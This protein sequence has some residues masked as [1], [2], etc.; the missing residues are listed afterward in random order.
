MMIAEVSFGI[1]LSIVIFL[2][3]IV[4]G[5][6][7][8]AIMIDERLRYLRLIIF[9]APSP[10]R[11]DIPRDPEPVARYL[12]WALGENR[13]PVAC[14]HL[15]HTGRIRYGKTGR[16]MNMGGEGYFSL[17]VPGFIWHATIT[18]APGIWLDAFD[19]Y[20]DREAGM[21]LNLFSLIPL[22]NNNTDEIKNSSLFHYLVWTPVFPMIHGLSDFITWEN[23]DDSTAKAIIQ[24]KDHAVEAI[25]RFDG[26]GWIDSME[27]HRK[28]PA[29]SSHPI[30]GYIASKFSGYSDVGGYQVPLQI[31]S[32]I[33]LPDG[34]L[35]CAEF[36][37][38]CIEFDDTDT[39]CQRKS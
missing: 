34:E 28:T 15:R 32:D 23:I 18:Y 24:D 31:T 26:R 6:D 36:T 13:H 27:I 8:F 3:L 11:A 16:W 4:I 2:F 33:I 5:N 20:V 9:Y 7:L 38:T 12:S 29:E 35:L 22:D 21:N 14:V 30:P 10:E 17:A 1:I 39:I 25:A 19:Y 37:L